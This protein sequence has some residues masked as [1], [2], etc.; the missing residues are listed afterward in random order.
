MY[1]ASGAV[2]FMYLKKLYRQNKFWFFIVLLFIIGQ[3]F[4]DYKRGVE[5]SPFYHYSMFSIPYQFVPVYEVTEV[6]VNGRRLQAKDFSPNGWDNIVIPVVLYQ[7]QQSWNRE[8]YETTIKRL[9]RTNDSSVYVN[10]LPPLQFDKW[11]KKRII[12]LLNLTDTSA[13]VEYRTLKYWRNNDTL[14]RR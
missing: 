12:R 5:F 7:H 8:L 14:L 13:A 2:F 11:Y 10:Q 1:R 9:L 3:L 6:T 4:I